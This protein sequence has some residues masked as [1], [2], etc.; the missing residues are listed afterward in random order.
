M[1]EQFIAKDGN[2]SPRLVGVTHLLQMNFTSIV[3]SC[4]LAF[5]Q[6]AAC[7]AQQKSVERLRSVLI[8]YQHNIVGISLKEL[9][10]GG[11]SGKGLKFFSG[12]EI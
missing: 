12:F 10:G 1:M 8:L 9:G 3:L 11:R 2:L 5:C 4:L 6:H 7:R